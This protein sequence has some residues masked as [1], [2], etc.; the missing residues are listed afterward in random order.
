MKK[1]EPVQD[2]DLNCLMHAKGYCLQYLTLIQL[3]SFGDALSIVALVGDPGQQT[4]IAETRFV[5]HKNKPLVDVAFVVDET[6]QG[7]GIASHLYQMLAKLA[8]EGGGTGH[9]G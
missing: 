3:V 6:Y 7:Y 2:I 4:I 9:D 1:H 5:K 8:K